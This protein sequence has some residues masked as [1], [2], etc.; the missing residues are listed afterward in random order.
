M[1]RNAKERVRIASLYIGPATSNKDDCEEAELLEVLSEVVDRNHESRGNN[2]ENR[3]VSVKIL[4]DENRAL[5][6]VPI[7]H[8]TDRDEAACKTTT[9]SAEAVARAIQG[10]LSVRDGEC[11]SSSLHLFRVLPTTTIGGRNWL[12][13]PLDEIAG[14]FHIKIYIVD[15]QLLLSGANLSREY[16]RDRMDRY[17][18]L[19]DGANGLVDFYAELVEILCR[20]SNEYQTTTTTTTT[21]A[22]SDNIV[23]QNRNSSDDFLREITQHFRDRTQD[24]VS[25]ASA[26]DLLSMGEQ[27]RKT[28]AVG[29]PTFQAPVGY[30]RQQDR[31]DND[32]N[33]C[34]KK[35]TP[36]SIARDLGVALSTFWSLFLIDQ[37]P[38]DEV[39]FVTDVEA[40]LNLLQEAG[41]SNNAKNIEGT[42]SSNSHYS[43]QMSSAYLNPTTS[44][45]SVLKK[46]FQTI[47]LL[48]AGKISHGFKP[49]K[50]GCN[51]GSQGKDWTIPS[52]FDK[53]VDECIHF[54]RSTTPASGSDMRPTSST[55]ARLFYWERPDWTFHAK[56]IWMT[57]EDHNVGSGGTKDDAA[58]EMAAVVVGSSNFGYRSFCRDMES[59]LLMIFPPAA[60]A[61]KNADDRAH[62]AR[63]FGAEWK[64][65]QASSK[66]EV[67]E[68]AMDPTTQQNQDAAQ[69]PPPLP[70][71]IL[72]SIPYIQSFF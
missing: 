20:H 9:S 42:T 48:T 50:T 68:T 43:V 3:R 40:T 29:I 24:A 12:P 23:R 35:P 44:L 58:R 62:I 19:V 15:D 37:Q 61:S 63:S 51:E 5:R 72:K 26:E 57:E 22:V 64:S 47:E 32:N 16:F 69:K 17:L 36:V 8:P 6:P 27:S 67:L 59:N 33:C 25:I 4:L 70:W 71:P 45:L 49:K 30:F 39:D 60:D 53:L 21:T 2:G 28:V 56:G 46:S 31:S 65:L 18:H 38:S 13:N 54:L 14:V 55:D 1:I 34:D 11:S 10:D 7:I 41:K 52:V 66:P